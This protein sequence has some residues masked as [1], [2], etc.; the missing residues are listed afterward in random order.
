MGGGGSSASH[1]TVLTLIGGSVSGVEEHGEP[2]ETCSRPPPLF[3]QLA[4]WAH[5]H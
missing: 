2:R 5:D 4:T 3:I 1:R